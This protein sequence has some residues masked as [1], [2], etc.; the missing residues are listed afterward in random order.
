MGKTVRQ[1]EIMNAPSPL[2]NMATQ[3]LA[4]EPSE[5]EEDAIAKAHAKQRLQATRDDMVV[6]AAAREKLSVLRTKQ[7]Q[8]IINAPSP[9]TNMAT[10]LLVNEQMEDEEDAI[11][12]LH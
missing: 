3:L 4:K 2:I 10:Q 6:K 1:Q 5:D 7:Q 8:E 9:L 12:K 11:T